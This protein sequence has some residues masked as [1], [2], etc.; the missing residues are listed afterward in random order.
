M[1]EIIRTL[2]SI[3]FLSSKLPKAYL[4]RSASD[5][6][7]GSR[8]ELKD[9]RNAIVEHLKGT[10]AADADL[11][12]LDGRLLGIAHRFKYAIEQGDVNA[13]W[14]AK[15]ALFIGVDK[16]RCLLPALPP[17]RRE[18]FAAGAGEYLEAWCGLI[19]VAGAFD[20]E[21]RAAAAAA[22]ETDERPTELVQLTREIRKKIEEEADYASDFRDILQN[23]GKRLKWNAKLQEVLDDLLRLAAEETILALLRDD[24]RAERETRH[25]LRREQLERGRMSLSQLREGSPGELTDSMKRALE[26]YRSIPSA[27]GEADCSEAPEPEEREEVPGS[28]PA[29]VIRVLESI[30]FLRSKLPKA[31]IEHSTSDDPDESRGDL[32]ISRDAAVEHLK[33]TAAA[34][35]DLSL[36]DGQLLDIAQRFRN[37]V[38]EGDVYAAYAGKA[39][40]AVGVNV[41]RSRAAAVSPE[42]AE[43]FLS[44]S[45]AFLKESSDWIATS[46]GY[47]G[48]ARIVSEAEEDADRR[49][50]EFSRLREYFRNKLENDEE[51]A[52]ALK[53]SIESPASAD[54]PKWSRLQWN[55]YGELI[56]RRV[57]KVTLGLSRC[58]LAA[59]RVVQR[60]A[61]GLLEELRAGFVFHQA[62][63]RAEDPD[64]MI[65]RLK[66][67]AADLSKAWRG[68]EGIIKRFDEWVEAVD[69]AGDRMEQMDSAW[70]AWEALQPALE[71]FRRFVELS[72]EERSTYPAQDV[73]MMIDALTNSD[74][75]T[76]KLVQAIS[77]AEEWLA[78]MEKTLLKTAAEEAE[79]LLKSWKEEL[80][81]NEDA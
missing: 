21:E 8:G 44:A 76:D 6:P 2:E 14:L 79:K 43:D 11:S 65:L 55:V 17:E 29:E 31:Y 36:L 37:A 26:D 34:D 59:C 58:R 32:E 77:T 12:P 68:Y 13:A 25:R 72:P 73:K 74:G 18:E 15:E 35:A 7:D 50:T 78:G 40:L 75:K 38:E 60:A 66:A 19:D 5:D 51:F 71:E 22:A 54:R 33:G 47:D 3:S 10:A 48:L 27:D 16:L 67:A 20:A 9:S 61:D 62:A 63:I 30:D 69:A 80:S 49:E 24:R 41:I 45:L 39:V 4:E 23:D 42:K 52:A 28:G 1:E 53:D 70:S 81:G 64:G 56:K 46:S 57:A